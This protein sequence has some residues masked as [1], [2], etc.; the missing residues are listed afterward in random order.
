[1]IRLSRFASN[2]FALPGSFDDVAIGHVA[3]KDGQATEGG[4]GGERRCG[5]NATVKSGHCHGASSRSRGRSMDTA[6]EYGL[7]PKRAWID[8]FTR[9]SSALI[10]ECAMDDSHLRLQVQQR[11]PV[12]LRGASRVYN[13]QRLD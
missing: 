10:V 12:H 2:R 1:M 5:H 7:N 13:A 11:L 6:S 4:G 8:R 9:R 3:G